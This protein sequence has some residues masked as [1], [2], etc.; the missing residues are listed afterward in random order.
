MHL[1]LVIV[2]VNRDYPVKE[3]HLG[4]NTRA[5]KHTFAHLL[6]IAR[7]HSGRFLLHRHAAGYIH[8]MHNEA[9]GVE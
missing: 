3:K 9:D 5:H 1:V 2:L 7:P 4:W 8:D 6:I